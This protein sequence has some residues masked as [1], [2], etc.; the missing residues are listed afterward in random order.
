MKT[1]FWAVAMMACAVACGGATTDGDDDSGS[2]KAGASGT[3]EKIPGV[4]RSSQ[5]T[6]LS[7]T[8]LAKVCDYMNKQLGGYGHQPN[9]GQ[10]TMVVP[11]DVS[12]ASCVSKVKGKSCTLTVGQV[13]DCSDELHTAPCS[14]PLDCLPIYTCLTG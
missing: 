9:C 1:T 2:S 14:L 6:S 13:E 5:V 3:A 11:A 12:Q 8:N 4:P 7:S 10:N